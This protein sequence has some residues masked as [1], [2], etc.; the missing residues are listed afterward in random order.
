MYKKEFVFEKQFAVPGY[1]SNAIVSLMKDL[2]IE[3]NLY[4]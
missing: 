4:Y 3:S 2:H 1:I